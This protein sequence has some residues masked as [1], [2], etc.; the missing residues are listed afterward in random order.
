MYCLVTRAFATR[1]PSSSI[2]L[3]GR[4][5][6]HAP[7]AD[8]KMVRRAGSLCVALHVV[9]VDVFEPPLPQV[10]YQLLLCLLLCVEDGPFSFLLQAHEPGLRTGL[11][12]FDESRLQQS[13]QGARQP[14]PQVWH[15]LVVVE[16]FDAALRAWRVGVVRFLRL[17]VLEGGAIVEEA[18]DTEAVAVAAGDLLL[19][20]GLLAD[21]ALGVE[22]AGERE[23][24]LSVAEEV[25]GVEG[26]AER[27]GSW[28]V[29]FT[30]M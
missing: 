26:L 21:G 2:S 13:G 18:R 22:L 19:W 29:R 15:L 17:H 23:R 20:H 27:H 6:L 12:E 24:R 30:G 7:A 8:S 4:L 3:G 9:P 28:G 14:L 25:R 1:R 5:L 16:H 10:V 11:V